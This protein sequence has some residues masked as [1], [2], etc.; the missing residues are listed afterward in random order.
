MTS[1]KMIMG[2]RTIERKEASPGFKAQTNFYARKLDIV[3]SS[4]GKELRN[5]TPF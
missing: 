4:K 1:R 3:K 5:Y 2:K